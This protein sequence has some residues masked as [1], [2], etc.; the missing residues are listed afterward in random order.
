MLWD[1][2]TLTALAAGALAQLSILSCSGAEFSSA[3]GDAGATAAAGKVSSAGQSTS[4]SSQGGKTGA[5]GS[6]SGAQAGGQT[7]SGGGQTNPGGG[8][9]AEPGFQPPSERLLY[10]FSADVG[11]MTEGGT[12]AMWQNRA[13]NGFNAVQV[14]NAMRPQLALD[15]PLPL[16][17]LVF[18]GADDYL[19]LPESTEAFA[20]GVSIFVI[21]GASATNDCAAI[22]ELSN[23]SELNDIHFGA[24]GNAVQYEV[25]QA[26]L[27]GEEGS[28]PVADVRLLEAHHSASL[29]QAPVELRVNGAQAGSTVMALPPSVPRISNFLGRT[30]YQNCG[31]FAGSVG[32]LLFYSRKVTADERTAIELYLLE[33]WQCCK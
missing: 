31:V 5:A 15:G 4:G 32:E 30:L 1:R 23:G 10:W 3:G 8:G 2:R 16:P 11:V 17:L 33:K 25:D 14:Q 27:V 24:H 29:P 21:A 13:E 9:T 7:N 19:E 12:V 18:D 6:A 20:E 22:V 28:L 26:V